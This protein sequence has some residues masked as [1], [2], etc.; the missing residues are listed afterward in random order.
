VGMERNARIEGV[1]HSGTVRNYTGEF[2]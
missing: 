2:E 1:Y